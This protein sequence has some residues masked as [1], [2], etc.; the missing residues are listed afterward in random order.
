M[1]GPLHEL[2]EAETPDAAEEIAVAIR[3][4]AA[5]ATDRQLFAIIQSSEVRFRIGL[6][7][8]S[9]SCVDLT[10][11]RN[12]DAAEFRQYVEARRELQRRARLGFVTR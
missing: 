11:M 5:K 9:G 2:S 1:L 8:Q 3:S 12:Y 7:G 6:D 4:L 10:A